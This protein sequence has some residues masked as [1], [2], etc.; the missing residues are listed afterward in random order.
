MGLLTALNHRLELS[1][2]PSC[3]SG[4]VDRYLIDQ[5]M[6]RTMT[7]D[8]QWSLAMEEKPPSDEVYRFDQSPSAQAKRLR[9]EARTA[10]SGVKRDE[11]LRRAIQIEAAATV[12]DWSSTPD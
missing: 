11:L 8:S 7:R 2:P 4:R 1:F 12:K 10:P 9:Q 3:W 5:A 6:R